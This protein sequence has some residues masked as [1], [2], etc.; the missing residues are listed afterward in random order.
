MLIS[1]TS[2]SLFCSQ[3]WRFCRSWIWVRTSSGTRGSRSSG[4]HWWSTAQCCSLAWPM[5]TSPVKV[6]QYICRM[7]VTCSTILWL[8][9]NLQLKETQSTVISS[10][11][12]K[13]APLDIT[14]SHVF[15]GE[16]AVALA[17]VL[18]ESQQIQQLDLRQNEV[19]VGGL[20]ALCLALRINSSLASLHLD[21]IPSHEQV[22]TTITAKD[23]TPLLLSVPVFFHWFVNGPQTALI[24]WYRQEVLVSF[25]I[26]DMSSI[27]VSWQ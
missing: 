5:P 17:E 18:A 15:F 16:G 26:L 9:F 6:Q 4:S 7:S 3:C 11:A 13:L 25:M 20:M 27:T 1:M 14:M 22:G 2:G 23:L 21:H 24:L 8:Y 12:T 19:K 10:W